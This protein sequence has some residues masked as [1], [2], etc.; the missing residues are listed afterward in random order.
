MFTE[1]Q[2]DDLSDINQPKF[3]RVVQE[4]LVDSCESPRL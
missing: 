3:N 4:Y 2:V 1:I